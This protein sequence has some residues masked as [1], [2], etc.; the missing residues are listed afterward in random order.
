MGLEES[1]MFKE[2][3]ENKPAIK[4]PFLNEKELEELKQEEEKKIYMDMNSQ[5]VNTDEREKAISKTA[6]FACSGRSL[7]NILYWITDKT[8]DYNLSL[9]LEQKKIRMVANSDLISFVKQTYLYEWLT[10]I[11]HDNTRTKINSLLSGSE[12]IKNLT[13]LGMTFAGEKWC[14]PVDLKDFH[15]HFGVTQLQSFCEI[16]EKVN[17]QNVKCKF[18]KKDLEFIL[19]NLKN[20]FSKGVVHLIKKFNEPNLFSN[21]H[22]DYK[23]MKVSFSVDKKVRQGKDDD[24]SY[25]FSLKVRNGLMSGWKL[26]SFLG[27]IFNLTLNR[28]CQRYSLLYSGNLNSDLNVLGD[29][30]HLKCRYLSHCL[31]Q[32]DLI[33]LIGKHAHPDKQMI[34]SIYT[35]FLK[36]TINSTNNDIQ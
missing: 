8:S 11:I 27:S 10:E 34:S 28:L 18:I 4:N 33:N 29:D 1:E 3:K 9:K 35:E 19:K 5:S 31:D 21:L 20:D 15:I 2:Y 26:T 6:T 24:Y 14:L 25:S 22:T 12:R 17:S 16:L 36:K 13:R 7:S 30:T 32:I 23:S